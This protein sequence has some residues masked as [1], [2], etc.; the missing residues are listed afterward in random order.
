M[1][2]KEKKQPVKKEAS[3]QSELAK[4]FHSNPV[5]FIGTFVILLFTVVAF[6]FVPAL[7]PKAGKGSSG[8][9]TFGSYDGKPIDFVPGNYFATQRDYYNQQIRSSGQ[10]QN[11]Q[12]AAF[13]VWRAAFESTVVRTAILSEMKDAGYLVPEELVDRKMAEYPAFQEEGR[14][15]AVKYRAMSE[16][17][18]MT[19]RDTMRDEIAVSRYSEDLM[20]LRISSKEKD[21]MKA[22][23]SPERSFEYVAFPISSYPDSE[24]S[25]Y[26]GSHPELFKS[27]GLSMIS[28]AGKEA[29]AEK[30]R[31]EASKDEAAFREYAKKHSKDSY[32]DK[33]GVLGTKYAYELKTL[34]TDE[35]ARAKVLDL[36]AGAV[37]GLIK[38]GDGW[39]F[40]RCD[41]S[42]KAPSATDAAALAKTREYLLSFERGKIEDWLIA[43]AETFTV[44]AKTGSFS[45]AAAMSGL[46]VKKF[47][48]VA[49]NYGDTELYRSI[50]S[51]KLPELSGASS[52]ESFLSTAFST[53]P[54]SIAKPV[55]VG[56]N[57]LVLRVDEERAADDS[58]L[59]VIDFY[60]PYVI[61]QYADKQLRNHFLGSKKL[62]DDFYNT[63]VTYFLPN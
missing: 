46:D 16:A 19:L 26:L 17:D 25:A 44:S 55:V 22:I 51:F 11:I 57:V 62:K 27:I 59:A 37:S 2:T 39:V 50:A 4:R 60:Y 42:A 43:K 28:L 14:F 35:A 5:L 18:R 61:G 8:K 33:G 20:D 21:F 32:A 40:F 48:P 63:F 15:S 45:S 7:A 30:I 47:G 10:D 52:N 49:L 9:L 36:G 53:P 13:Q 12:L 54:A 31:G 23:A 1:T 58:S 24:V 29:D 3:S 56:N 6:V 41:E 34:I 38:S